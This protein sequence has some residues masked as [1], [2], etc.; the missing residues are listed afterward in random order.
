MNHNNT[1]IYP[2]SRGTFAKVSKFSFN[3]DNYGKFPNV[4]NG[5]FRLKYDKNRD[6]QIF[7]KGFRGKFGQNFPKNFCPESFKKP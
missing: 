2:R 7:Y 5:H 4:L 3:L 1:C 6:T